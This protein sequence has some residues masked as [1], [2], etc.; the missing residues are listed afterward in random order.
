ML[1]NPDYDA[2]YAA[3]VENLKA[4]GDAGSDDSDDEDV[5]LPCED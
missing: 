1:A 2:Q 3:V 5:C 4:L